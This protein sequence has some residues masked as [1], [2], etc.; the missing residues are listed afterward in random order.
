MK[1]KAEETTELLLQNVVKLWG[2]PQSIISD[3]DLRFTE[4]FWTSLFTLLGMQLNFSTAF[5]PYIDGQTER[6]N[7]I[8]EQYLRHYISAIQDN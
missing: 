3:R 7:S 4:W 2:I 8:L 6:V 5:Y 1:C